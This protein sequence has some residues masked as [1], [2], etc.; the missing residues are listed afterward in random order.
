MKKSHLSIFSARVTGVIGYRK[1]KTGSPSEGRNNF[2]MSLRD[3]PE[4]KRSWKYKLFFMA[5]FL[6]LNVLWIKYISSTYWSRYNVELKGYSNIDIILIIIF[7][8]K[9]KLV[10]M[11]IKVDRAYYIKCLFL[12]SYKCSVFP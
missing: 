8:I 1:I 10:V 11:K 4:I 6:Y 5:I 9:I 7:L 12:L 3:N 2:I